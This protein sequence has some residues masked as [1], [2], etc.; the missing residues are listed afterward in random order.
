MTQLSAGCSRN[1]YTLNRQNSDVIFLAEGPCGGGDALRGLC[2]DGAGAFEAIELTLRIGGFY[3]AIGEQCK[4]LAG[5][6]LE[7]GFGVFNIRD[8]AQGQPRLSLDLDFT[9][10]RRQVTG[11]CQSD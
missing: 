2:A 4:C 10:I 11:I 8:E 7:F 1:R 3:N 5:S 9:A 6:Q